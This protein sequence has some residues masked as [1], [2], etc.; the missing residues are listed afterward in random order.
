[1][2]ATKLPGAGDAS[3]AEPENLRQH[4]HTQCFPVQN[5]ALCEI[6]HGLWKVQGVHEGSKGFKGEPSDPFL[7]LLMMMS[8]TR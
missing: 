8:E 3:C 6:A 5:T 2:I 4:R 7:N 1:M